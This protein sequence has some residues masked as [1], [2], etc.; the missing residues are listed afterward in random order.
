MPAKKEDIPSTIERSPKKVQD[1]YEKTLDSAHEQYDSEERAHRTAFA[2]LK[3]EYEKVGDHWERK[4]ESG[5]SDDRAAQRGPDGDGDRGVLG[6]CTDACL[7]EGAACTFS[8]ACCSGACAGEP[9]RCVASSSL[10]R[11]AAAP[12]TS[13]PAVSFD[14]SVSGVAEDTVALFV[15][16]PAG[17][18][19]AIDA[20]AE[21][22]A[23]INDR[24]ENIGARRLATVLERLL[25]E[26]SFTASDRRGDTVRVD[27]AMVQDKVGALA[28]STDLSRF[29]L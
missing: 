17:V 5:P 16:V 1:T 29:I 3:H 27:A 14:G 4:A 21:M 15:S 28:A 2:A 23:D 24:V 18:P 26:V 13:A 12:S 10:C 22:A 7:A 25:E 19:D 6:R 9:G 11:T 8:A 20:V